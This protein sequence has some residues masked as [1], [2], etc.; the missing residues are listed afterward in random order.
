MTSID[1]LTK[2]FYEPYRGLVIIIAPYDE[3]DGGGFGGAYK[4]RVPEGAPIDVGDNFESRE[5]AIAAC[6]RDID[7]ALDKGGLFE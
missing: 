1:Q 6:K 7:K 3:R 2:S 4:E 5:A